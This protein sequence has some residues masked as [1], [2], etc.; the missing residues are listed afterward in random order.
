LIT[1]PNFIGGGGSCFP[2][3]VIVALGEPGTPLICWACTTLTVNNQ[4]IV[5]AAPSDTLRLVRSLVAILP[6]YLFCG[7]QGFCAIDCH[8]I[9]RL[10]AISRY[11]TKVQWRSPGKRTTL[12][13]DGREQCARLRAR[14]EQSTPTVDVSEAAIAESLSRRNISPRGKTHGA[15]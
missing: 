12:S 14:I 9:L 1:P 2:S 11:C 10:A 4:A 3:S 13:A 8:R 6:T 7:Y 5:N 15:G